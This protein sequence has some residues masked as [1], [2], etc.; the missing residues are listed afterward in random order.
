MS[1]KMG[2]RG[3]ERREALGLTQRQLADRIGT[4]QSVVMR[5]ENDGSPK[6]DAIRRWA[7]ALEMSFDDLAFDPEELEAKQERAAE[8]DVE[9]QRSAGMR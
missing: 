9:T 5:W 1:Y 6:F 2:Q 8:T 7:T 4:S 3:K